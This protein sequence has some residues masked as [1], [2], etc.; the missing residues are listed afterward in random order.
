MNCTED[1]YVKFDKGHFSGAIFMDLHLKKAF[2]TFDQ[3]ILI[4]K[5]RFY[6]VEGVEFD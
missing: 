2:D 6:V 3:D 4:T 1:W 5:L